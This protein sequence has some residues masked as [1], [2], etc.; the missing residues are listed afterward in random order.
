MAVAQAGYVTQIYA[1]IGAEP[2]G[3][4]GIS[5]RELYS[6]QLFRKLLKPQA[7]RAAAYGFTKV[8]YVCCND[9][10]IYVLFMPGD[11]GEPRSLYCEIV[12]TEE[13]VDAIVCD[14]DYCSTFDLSHLAGVCPNYVARVNGIIRA[15]DDR[16]AVVAALLPRPIAT[17]IAREMSIEYAPV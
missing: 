6:S 3:R 2:F 7:V 1:Q 5:L 12:I 15:R 9:D 8:L 16:A 4:G 11:I 14:D 10:A 17:K 13:S